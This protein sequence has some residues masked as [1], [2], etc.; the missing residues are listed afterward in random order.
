[1]TL[2]IESNI[3]CTGKRFETLNAFVA[4]IIGVFNST[5]E[6]K[7]N[8]ETNIRRMLVESYKRL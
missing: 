5:L 7:K 4:P 2:I 6:I 3:Q 1:M 8:E